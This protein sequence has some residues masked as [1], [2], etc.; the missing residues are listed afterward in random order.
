MKNL[1]Q[2]KEE[3]KKLKD[4]EVYVVPESDYGKAE[5][6]KKNSRYFLFEIPLYG[7]EPLFINVYRIEQLDDIIKKVDSWT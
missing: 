5:I 2:I 4:G 1:D 3:I 7:G 6:W